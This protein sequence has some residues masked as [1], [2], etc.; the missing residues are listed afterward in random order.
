MVVCLFF[1][2]FFFLERELKEMNMLLLK[3]LL[4]VIVVGRKKTVGEL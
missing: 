2:F 1:P 4:Y 3:W